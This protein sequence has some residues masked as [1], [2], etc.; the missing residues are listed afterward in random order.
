MDFNIN[1]TIS[2]HGESTTQNSVEKTEQ[3]Y[4][5]VF[6]VPL[7]D[8]VS[9]VAGLTDDDDELA[10]TSSLSAYGP[11]PKKIRP[12]NFDFPNEMINIH[13]NHYNDFDPARM[14]SS[15]IEVAKSDLDYSTKNNI[16][17]CDN[18][19]DN[20]IT[21][22]SSKRVLTEDATKGDEDT[23][24][25]SKDY[26]FDSYAHHAI[27]EEMLKDEVR[28]R[29]YEMAIMQNKHLFKDKVRV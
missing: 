26:Y 1:C 3:D 2:E 27:H 22:N 13:N 17:N 29:T 24:P 21:K 15:K 20:D 28:T 4:H 12:C 9:K 8:H 18:I 25:T 10:E 11:A 6:E 14:S 7:D 16:H 5:R 19:N 23:D